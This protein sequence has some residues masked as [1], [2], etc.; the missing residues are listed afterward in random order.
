VKK[1]FLTIAAIVILALLVTGFTPLAAGG[2]TQRTMNVTGTGTVKLEPDI[3]H[4]NIGVRS[5]SADIQE[6]FVDNNNSAKTIIETL[7]S[8]GVDANDI[9]TQNFYIYQQQN[10]PYYRTEEDIEEQ[11]P[12]M[13]YVV[14][15]TV[16]TTVR[17]L[18]TL[19]EIL[20]KVVEEGAN[21]IYGVSFDVADRE[22]ALEEARSMAIKDAQDRA[23]AIAEEA[24]VTLGEIQSIQMSQGSYY[25]YA[26]PS[27][28]VEMAAGGG[29]SVPI[30]EGLMKIE[31]TI[32][33]TYTFN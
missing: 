2:E 11:E 31:V 26:E 17:N 9:Q 1:T 21:T 30:S 10:Q 18:E 29:G 24:E 33:M 25:Q 32:Y 27:A 7:I 8:M 3:A 23:V 6:A 28:R 4:V 16:S 13:T 15:N 12:Q 19:G 20:S 22:A 5:Q 14:E